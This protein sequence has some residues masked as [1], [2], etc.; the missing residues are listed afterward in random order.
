MQA[1]VH[2]M[3]QFNL[4]VQAEACI[5]LPGA[6]SFRLRLTGNLDVGHLHVKVVGSVHAVMLIQIN[7]TKLH[8][9]CRGVQPS[10]DSRTST[11]DFAGLLSVTAPE[12]FGILLSPPGQLLAASPGTTR[13]GP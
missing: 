6:N 11:P 12:V 2:S 5:T 4:K 9:R 8:F 3:A 1:T 10:S 13:A 7:R